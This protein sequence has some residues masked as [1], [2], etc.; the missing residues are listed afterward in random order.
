MIPVFAGLLPAEH[1]DVVLDVLFS[2]CIVH[3]L[4]KFRLHTDDSLRLL[5]VETKRLGICLRRFVSVVC[6]AY[7]TKELPKEVLARTRHAT[8]VATVRATGQ[9]STI[10]AGDKRPRAHDGPDATNTP[11]KVVTKAFSLST[12][13]LHSIGHYKRVISRKGT[14][15]NYNTQSVCLFVLLASQFANIVLLLHRASANIAV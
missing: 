12:P 2:F 14:T 8:R 1:E 13:K 4:S 9:N 6:A 3:G 10:R 11:R 5:E 15:D 7:P